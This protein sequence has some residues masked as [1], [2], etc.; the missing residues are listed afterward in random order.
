MVSVAV[1]GKYEDECFAFSTTFYRRYTSLDGD[2]GASTILFQ[3]TLKTVGTFGYH[4]L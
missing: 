2:D 1:S 4:A 3:I